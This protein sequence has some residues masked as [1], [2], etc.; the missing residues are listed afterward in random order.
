MATG[1][2]NHLHWLYKA[3]LNT[4]WAYCKINNNYMCR[5]MAMKVKLPI[6]IGKDNNYNY[7]SL[8]GESGHLSKN[9][10]LTMV[11]RG[12]IRFNGSIVQ[13]CVWLLSLKLYSLYSCWLYPMWISSSLSH[14]EVMGTPTWCQPCCTW[15]APGRSDDAR[16]STWCKAIHA[17]SDQHKW[18]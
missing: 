18:E 10:C 15:L 7:W 17:S 4:S 12:Q 3:C 8:L 6:M 14:R 2:T 5:C 13:P 1:T 11:S 16:L 9:G